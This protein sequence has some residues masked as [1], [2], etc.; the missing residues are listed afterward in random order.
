MGTHLPN[1]SFDAQQKIHVT[2]STVDV[3]G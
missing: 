2:A 1:K 3:I